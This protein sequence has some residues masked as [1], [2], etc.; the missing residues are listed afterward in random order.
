M[1]IEKYL[2]TVVQVFKQL[3]AGL[4]QRIEIPFCPISPVGKG[5]TG[6]QVLE[7]ANSHLQGVGQ[8]EDD[9]GYTKLGLKGSMR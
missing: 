8:M 1:L 5:T 4:I 7:V 2:D 3:Y 9:R 6:S